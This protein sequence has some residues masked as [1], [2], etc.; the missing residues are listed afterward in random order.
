MK[1]VQP[2][3][4]QYFFVLCCLIVLLVLPSALQASVG[5]SRT[6]S[7]VGLIVPVLAV[8]AASD[9]R[10]HRRTAIGL[11]AVCALANAEGLAHFTALPHG[12]G[13]AAALVFLA[14]TTYLLLS[15]VLRSRRVTADVIAGALASYLMIGLTWALAYGLV[16]MMA[17]GS[18]GVASGARVD[19]HTLVYYSYITLMTIGYG[20]VTPVTAAARTLA[21][22]EGLIGVAFTTIVLAALVAMLLG[23]KREE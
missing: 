18:I 5:S 21:V 7:V 12:V 22:F 6:L 1:F 8:A 4:P 11:A 13:A 3:R 9:T 15:G 2:P 17:P 10:R 14:Y 19:L 23:E 16:E 20:D